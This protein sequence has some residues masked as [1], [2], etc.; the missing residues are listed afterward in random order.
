MSDL[1]PVL[2]DLPFLQFG[3]PVLSVARCLAQFVELRIEAVAKDAAFLKSEW[4]IIEERIIQLGRQLRHLVQIVLQ[5][6]SEQLGRGRVVRAVGA[7]CQ[8]V[9]KFLQL[10]LEA[11]NLLKRC[12]QRDEIARVPR[13]LAEPTGSAFQ[14]ANSLQSIA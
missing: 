11:G 1:I 8:P 13:G 2:V 3:D 12:L 14:V 7:K 4:G 9:Q 10:P 6:L 5:T